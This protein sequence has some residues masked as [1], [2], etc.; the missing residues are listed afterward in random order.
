[1]LEDIQPSLSHFPQCLRAKSL[2]S[3]PTL[4]SHGLQ[5]ARLLC[6]W[7]SPGKNSAVGCHALLQGISLTLGL[8]PGLLHCRQVLQY[9]CHLGSNQCGT[10]ELCATLDVQISH[11]ASYT[12]SSSVMRVVQPRP[13]CVDSGLS[14]PSQK[15]GRNSVSM[16]SGWAS[17][18][19]SAWLIWG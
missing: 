1:M 15:A 2:Q 10:F 16:R 3:C 8:N 18:R 4:T 12:E 13:V 7:D 9:Q 14:G 19:D 6:P 11:P 17:R 5:T